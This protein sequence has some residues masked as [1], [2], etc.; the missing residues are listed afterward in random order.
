VTK[1]VE[2]S[3]AV[4]RAVDR[5]GLALYCGH[6]LG[7]PIAVERE[8]GAHLERGG[9]MSTSLLHIGAF[10][11]R[12]PLTEEPALSRLAHRIAFHSGSTR[13][14]FG[15]VRDDYVPLPM[16]RLKDVHFDVAFLLG[17]VPRDGRVSLGLS[18]F[19]L[20]VA[21]R[22]RISV[23]EISP[24]VPFIPGD[25]PSV[26]EFDFVVEGDWRLPDTDRREP[27]DDERRI[28]EEVSRYVRDGD[29]VQIGFGAVP[30]ALCGFLGERRD[31]GI[32][33]EQITDGL[34]ELI[35]SGVANGTRKA[36]DV[37]KAIA[38][39]AY[40]SR[41]LYLWLEDNP[42][43][44]MRDVGY[45]D[46]PVEIAKNPR[47]I[48]VNSALQV[49]L[50][51]CVNA[52]GVRGA[53]MGGMGGQLDFVRGA[54]G[55]VGGRSIIALLSTAGV[56][57]DRVSRIVPALGPGEPVSGTAHDSDVV[58]TEFG[59]VELIGR[60]LRERHEA[61]IGIA[62]PDFRDELSARS[63]ELL[64]GRAPQSVG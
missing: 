18:W 34:A 21:R 9:Y 20:E 28:G 14:A 64:S 26:D 62:H 53:Y 63:A 56:G 3:K 2:V 51:G 58:C 19:G 27:S 17:S 44:Y 22:A 10:Y 23:L 48:A 8:L 49:D 4:T 32:H 60:T 45:V 55:S 30:D 39:A 41:G 46:N 13:A 50:N 25:C 57:A 38:S 31:L 29:T 24:E 15:A 43:V 35:T 52:E 5:D 37:G 7:Q 59:S 47:F 6:S 16:S 1:L 11:E 40:G 33:S 61:L 54:A 12:S 42:A 36:V